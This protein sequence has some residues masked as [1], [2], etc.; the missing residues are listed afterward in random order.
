M[1]LPIS[2]SPGKAAA[3][4]R[5]IALALSLAGFFVSQLLSPAGAA[6]AFSNA[7]L[8]GTCGLSV[9]AL[10]GSGTSNVVVGVLTF[11][12]SGNLSGQV[13]AADNSG[14]AFTPFTAISGGSYSVNNDGTGNA[15]FSIGGGA[16]NISFAIDDSNSEIRG[17][18][19]KSGKASYFRCRMQTAVSAI[20]GTSN[21]SGTY[22]FLFAEDAGTSSVTTMGSSVAAGIIALDG[23]GHLSGNAAFNTTSASSF[24][25]FSTFTGG[26]YTFNPTALTGSMTFTPQGGPTFTFPFTVSDSFSQ[27]RG[28]DSAGN[29]A[30]SFQAQLQ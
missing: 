30:G 20:S 7:S 17:I 15:T 23:A 10:N 6:A 28:M 24:Q 3:R 5:R 29:V 19:Q 26:T 21:L 14:D 12:G 8:N 22:A 1:P 2:A 16:N 11:D 25:P 18:D 27:L 13:S 9:V 4:F